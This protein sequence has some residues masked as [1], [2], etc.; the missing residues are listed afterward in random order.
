MN[1]LLLWGLAPLLA[2]AVGVARADEPAKPDD[3]AKALADARTK[4]LD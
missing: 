2:C 1:R 4:G 3:A